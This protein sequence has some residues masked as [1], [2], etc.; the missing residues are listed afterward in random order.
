MYAASSAAQIGAVHLWNRNV[1]YGR[2]R[3]HE[4][5]MVVQAFNRP[6][7]LWRWGKVSCWIPVPDLDIVFFLEIVREAE[8]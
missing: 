6:V 2:A 8:R 7:L 1:L 4:R 3:L 5:A